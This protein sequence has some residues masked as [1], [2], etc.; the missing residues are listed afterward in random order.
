MEREN[1]NNVINE[2]NK[3]AR[4]NK[5]QNKLENIAE[6]YDEFIEDFYFI[7]WLRISTNHITQKEELNNTIELIE[8]LLEEIEISIFN[9]EDKL[10]NNCIL[11]LMYNKKDISKLIENFEKYSD[12][13]IIDIILN[14][15]YSNF[16]E[17]DEEYLLLKLEK[18][19]QGGT[20]DDRTGIQKNRILFI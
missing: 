9:A 17:I 1:L 4:L 2:I 15:A 3:I 19:L 7:E 18:L 10:Y 6:E 16:Y 8:E 12:E 11:L 14:F 20:D 5:I 13:Y